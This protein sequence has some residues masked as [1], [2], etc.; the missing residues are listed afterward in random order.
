MLRQTIARKV[1]IEG[2]GLHRG[3]TVHLSIN[4][5]KDGILFI[6]DGMEIPARSDFVVD[7]RLNTRLGSE[8]V[9]IST[10]EHL[11]SALYGL[12]IT[13]CEVH[14]DGDEMPSMDGS[15]L[16]FFNALSEAGTCVIGEIDPIIVKS[17]LRVGDD[18]TYVEIGPGDFSVSYSIDF[19]EPAI[20]SQTYVY[21]GGDYKALIAPAR[22][23]GRL[24]DVDAMRTMGLAL[25]GSLENA[26]VVDNDIILNPEGLRF[27]DEFVRHKILDLLG[28]LWL[29][30]R[31]VTGSIK[32]ARANHR[33]H[34][35][36]A[37]TIWSGLI[38]NRE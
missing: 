22:T 17:R 11:M 13:D 5:G 35:E 2:T 24:K 25:G 36:L 6:R 1:A 8:G 26:I 12:G 16:P 28:D 4:A 23:F 30:G 37:R 32:A 19:T 38:S 34:V 18:N 7:T 27:K 9:F 21:S 3:N 14:V 31:P 15:A 10:V 20:G 33:L 29:L